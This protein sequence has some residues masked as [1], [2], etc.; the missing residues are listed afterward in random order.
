MY[1]MPA[2]LA[3]L[4][5]SSALNFTGLKRPASR[6][7]SLTGTVDRNITHSPRPSDRLPFH[8]PAGRAYS[9]QWMKRPYFASRNHSRRFSFAGSRGALVCARGCPIRN[10]KPA[11]TAKTFFM[12]SLRR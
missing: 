4:T 10:A 2:S 12:L 9:P 6:S 7:Y 5:H 1:F 11:Q 8:S 3:S